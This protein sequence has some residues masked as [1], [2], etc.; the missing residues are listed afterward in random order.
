MLIALHLFPSPF[1]INYSNYLRS[2]EIFT[3]WIID[4]LGSVSVK[5]LVWRGPAVDHNFADLPGNASPYWNFTTK[6]WRSFKQDIKSTYLIPFCCIRTGVCKGLRVFK[7]R[8]ATGVTFLFYFEENLGLF[9]SGIFR[10]QLCLTFLFVKRFIEVL[11]PPTKIPRVVGYLG[12]FQTRANC[13]GKKLRFYQFYS[14][15]IFITAF[16]TNFTLLGECNW[17]VVQMYYFSVYLELNV[18]K[19]IKATLFKSL[20]EQ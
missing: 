18:Y 1:D 16:K 10:K 5:M 9:C 11:A 8:C 15:L 2:N 12:E 6:G 17:L 14:D 19:D 3:L 13:R 7:L 4:Y 20:S